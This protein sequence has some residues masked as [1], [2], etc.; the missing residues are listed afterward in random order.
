[1]DSERFLK[2]LWQFLTF[3]G[4]LR[5]SEMFSLILS[6]SERILNVLLHSWTFLGVLR[7]S[8]WFWHIVIDFERF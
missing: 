4:V 5:H 3:R 2:V 7:H 6:C 1:M 8:E